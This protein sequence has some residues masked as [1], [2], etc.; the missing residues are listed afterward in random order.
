L[1]SDSREH[2][3]KAEKGKNRRKKG[4]EWKGFRRERA[5]HLLEEKRE[6]GR[7]PRLKAEDRLSKGRGKMR[8]VLGGRETGNDKRKNIGRR[9]GVVLALLGHEEKSRTEQK[10][11]RKGKRRLSEEAVNCAQSKKTALW[12]SGSLPY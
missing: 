4:R 11:G 9:A 6:P 10:G 12:G 1:G 2:E 5:H 7:R 3:K 8:E